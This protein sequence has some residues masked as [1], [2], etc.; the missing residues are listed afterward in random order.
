[1]SQAVLPPPSDRHADGDSDDLLEFGY[2]QQL[3]RKLGKFAS[4]AAGFSFV[5][6]LTTI[7]QLF[8]LSFSFAGPA[9]FWAWP[10][11]FVGQFM[12]ALCFAELAARYPIS[13]AIYQWSRRVGGEITGW[14]AGWFM[15]IAQIVTAS[16]AA[17]ALQVV[18]PNVW[19]GFQ[20]VGTD[21]A[22][23]SSDGATNAVVL[24]TALLVITTTINSIGVNAMARINSI[25][26]TCEIVGVIAVIGVFFTHA[27]RGPDVVFDTGGVP[28]DSGYI[29]AWIVSG[30]MAAYVMVGFGSAGELAEE[31]K[32]PRRVA[33]RTI[34]LALSV[35]AL[36]GGLMI[37]G[38]LMAAPSLT[39]GELATQ[40]LPYVLNSVLS[41]PWGTV[42]LID[43]AIAILICTLAIQT[44]A[45]RL[46][47]S[48]A[49]DGRL[50]G[51]R[52]LGSVNK[53]TGTPIA[54]A[55]VIGLGCVLVLVVNV[56]NSA[57]FS[58][59]ASVCIVL[60]YLAYMM[61]T[62]PLL[63]Q[64]LKGW[65]HNTTG[66]PKVDSEGKPLF[67]LG[68][69]GLPVN[70]LAVVYGAVMV[71]NLSWPRPEI[72]D[73]SGDF[74]LLRWA[75]P[76]TVLAV[77]AVGALCFPR[78]KAHPNPVTTGVSA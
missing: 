27:Q 15:I 37:I 18:L 74:P 50:P 47:F 58:T 6:I 39:D 65:P 9:F 24:G 5:S 8:G 44:A 2:E 42:L 75:A 45:S 55:V 40:G 36:G 76:L 32:N 20:I 52:I 28:V 64:R 51:S 22:L 72:Y 68:R 17:I 53:T 11:V 43:V 19:S 46:M 23:T 25:G 30:L 34:R 1:M 13:G 77:V 63:L 59:L 71:V 66:A 10:V 61:V 41:S 31:T 16:A 67:T 38:A 73:P 3:H 69:L 21:T 35:S 29:G 4:F 60:I 26:V 56:G 70:I 78:G 54:P 33:P 48:M 14:F 7:F 12:V 62:V 49:R 57:I